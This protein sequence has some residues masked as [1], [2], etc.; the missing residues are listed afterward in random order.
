MLVIFEDKAFWGHSLIFNKLFAR[1][2]LGNTDFCKE[3]FPKCTLITFLQL[4]RPFQLKSPQERRI[5]ELEQQIK[6]LRERTEGMQHEWLR[7]Q[8]HVVKL[9]QQHQKVLSDIGLV[10]KRKRL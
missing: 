4:I 10:T 9:T 7:L 3:T 5:E 8:G 2:T 1:S 6:S